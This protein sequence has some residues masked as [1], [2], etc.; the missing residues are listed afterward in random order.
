[1]IGTTRTI[2]ANDGIPTTFSQRQTPSKDGCS[3]SKIIGRI[4]I[5]P[6]FRINVKTDRSQWGW[7]MSKFYVQG[8]DWT[9]NSPP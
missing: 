7:G 1:M 5:R 6:S 2:V 8:N 4:E 9:R 3:W